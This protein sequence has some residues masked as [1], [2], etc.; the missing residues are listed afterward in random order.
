MKQERDVKQL[1]GAA[2]IQ[3]EDVEQLKI[4]E[5]Y[6]ENYSFAFQVPDGNGSFARM[7]ETAVKRHL[8][9]LGYKA[10]KHGNLSEIDSV[11]NTRMLQNHVSYADALAGFK[12]GLYDMNGEHVL[13]TS[14]PN[15]LTPK[16]RPFPIIQQLLDNLFGPVQLPYFNG[17]MKTAVE[18]FRRGRYQQLQICALCGP[19]KAGKNRLQEWI[20][21]PLLG[22]RSANPYLSMT[23]SSNYNLE[24]FKA[25][26]LMLADENP[27]TD[28]RVRN[29]MAAYVKQI[30][31]NEKR[32]CHGK[33]KTAV[34]LSPR[35][36]L[37]TSCNDQPEAMMVIP[38]LETG[39]SD[40]IMLFHVRECPMPMPT[41]TEDEQ[42]RFKQTVL[43]ECPAYLDYLLK[44]RIP[45]GLRD[46]RFLVATYHNP[47]LVNMLKW[48]SDEYQFLQIIDACLFGGAGLEARRYWTG[49]AA[50]LLVDLSGHGGM[51]TQIDRLASNP[52]KCGI[53]LA[54][55]EGKER[56][57]TE[58][59][60][61]LTKTRD[62]QIWK[63]IAPGQPS[64]IRSDRKLEKLAKKRLPQNACPLCESLSCVEKHHYETKRKIR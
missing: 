49:T 4:P 10:T 11:V 2:E 60:R 41:R 27:F 18:A 51:K 22:G 50:K 5:M 46:E 32:L 25:E 48:S 7:N 8:L 39:V 58:R 3:P 64:E 21:T 12:I 19:P 16:P 44:W 15:Y 54:K 1:N 33:Y 34:T 6:Y 31:A 62:N 23:G 26:H 38:P 47:V 52:R 53:L 61:R 14:S 36:W 29:H 9:K 28:R 13:V 40:K 63:I 59:V 30:S 55:L 57:K 24:T 45:E 37:T 42:E 20:I 56:G 17:W 43:S 35:N